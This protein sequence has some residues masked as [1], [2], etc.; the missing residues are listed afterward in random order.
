[1]KLEWSRAVLHLDMDAFYVNVHILD[2][3]NDAGI[4]LVVGGQPDKRGVVSSASYEARRLG[5]HSAMPTSRAVRLCPQLKIVPANWPRIRE[6]S[7]QVMALLA[8]YGPV[9]QLS[10]DEAFVD[11]RRFTQ[12][13]PLA[14]EIQAAVQTT[15]SLPCSVGLG[16]SKLVAKIASDFEKPQGC[17]VVLPAT[18][19]AFLAPLP[20][21]VI[22]G[23]GPKTA[24]RLEQS[25][26]STCGQLAATDLDVLRAQFG[27]QAADFRQ[28]ARGIDPR[29]VEVDRG[30]AKSISQEWTFDR[31]VNDALILRRKLLTMVSDITD[32]LR[33]RDLVAHTVYI[34]LR[35]RDF[36][37]I[38]RQKTVEIALDSEE[39]IL[40]A[41][42][43]L[44]AENWHGQW[45]RLLGVGLSKL[46]R[47]AARQLGFDF[48]GNESRD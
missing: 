20:V 6:C 45:V 8:E 14:A 29:P 34:K 30:P 41:A 19:E 18:E 48:A 24:E 5:I 44:L 26:I 35:W 1:M 27:K 23:I 47:A 40:H 10:V 33:R 17:T 11:L 2:H 43:A 25:G 22:W 36:T 21:R 31:D 16:T 15:T 12:P 28:R 42:D 37:T 46:E 32:V 13:E 9:E 39:E 7:R 4:P 3:P 38:T